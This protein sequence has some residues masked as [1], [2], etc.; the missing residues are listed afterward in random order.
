MT[1]DDSKEGG[2]GTLRNENPAE[3]IVRPLN[4]VEDEPIVRRIENRNLYLGNW[5]AADPTFHDRTF[6]Y[7]LSLSTD[8]HPLTTHHHPLDD[9]PNNEWAVFEQAV[10][11][12]VDLYCQ[13][14]SL[15]IHCTAG[16]S[17]S[18]VLI[19]VVIAAEEERPFREALNIVQQARPNAM[20]HPELHK[21]AVIYLAAFT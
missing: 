11:A 13:D 6:D 4:Y 7:V 15:L 17:R 3:P 12:A 18:S 14:G 19:A 2:D 8:E 10:K 16:I 20:P 5:L 9:G 21:L 1:P